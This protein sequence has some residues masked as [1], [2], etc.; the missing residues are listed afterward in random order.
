M[1]GTRSRADSWWIEVAWGAWLAVNVAAV[2]LVPTG[3]TIP[4][5]FIWLS[6]ALVYGI[7]LWTFGATLW[8]LLG[9]CALS[10]FALTLALVDSHQGLDEAAEV[11]MMGA[12][13]LAMVWYA[14]RWKLAVE[15][16]NRASTRERDFIRDA[17]HQLRTPITVARGHLELVRSEIPDT[18]TVNDV[19]IV[20]GE[21]DRLARI[22]DR[23]LILATAEYV[24]FVA[25][26]PVNL[27]RVVTASVQRWR[28]TVPRDWNVAAHAHGTLVGDEERIEV[29]LDALIENAIK[30]TD[31]GDRIAVELRAEDDCA[32]IEVS[33]SGRGI[34]SGDLDRVFDRFWR[35]TDYGARV[36][37]GTGLGLAIV[38]AIAEGHGGTVEA[39]VNSD[40]GATFR[41]R[42]HGFVS[43]LWPLVP[44]VPAGAS[45]TVEG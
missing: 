16:L 15:E 26:A 35:S 34:A 7:R 33:D 41:M 32:V 43:V 11:P 23:L 2:I 24:G 39:L 18:E 13:F 6:L 27:N 3:E 36:N 25:R 10:G 19:D 1:L 21:L 12:L 22:S 40:G 30:A 8:V 29:A 37:G 9:I 28:S 20:L 31:V 42:L 14:S 38:K 44:V 5:H 17:S 45:P 4:F